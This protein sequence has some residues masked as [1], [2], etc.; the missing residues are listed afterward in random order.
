MTPVDVVLIGRNEGDR[1]KAALV[2]VTGV[3]RQIVYV[4]SGSTDDSVAAAQDVGAT[5]VPLDMRQPFSAARARNAGFDAL[6]DPQFVLFID[7]DCTLEPGFAEAARDRLQEDPTLALVTGWRS[8]IHRDASLY[9]QLCDWEWHRP[10]GLID[11]CGGDMMVRAEAWRAV[12]GMNPQVIAAEDDEVCTRLRKAGWALERIPVKMTRHDAA[13]LRFGQWWSRAVRTGHG[14]AQVGHLHPDYFVT[15]RKRVLF[16]GLALPVAF[17]LGLVF[18][19]PLS[20]LVLF[21]YGL[22]YTRTAKG[23]IAE[24]LN[25]GEAWRHARLLTLSKLPNML[26]FARFHMRRLS[27]GPMR[28]IEYK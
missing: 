20:G 13:M 25:A 19:L 26:G 5:V 4:D 15:E 7:G 11:A 14:F 12:G 23:L 28:I 10:A 3:A 8:E 2:S 27:G 9:N 6:R 18:A 1:L 16:Y 21:V 17:G 24:G 22:N